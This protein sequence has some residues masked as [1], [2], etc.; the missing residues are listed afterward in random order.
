M[1][2]Y[3]D[4]DVLLDTIFESRIKTEVASAIVCDLSEGDLFEAFVSPIIIAN[5]YYNIISDAKAKGKKDNLSLVELASKIEQAKISAK[6]SVKE[7][8]EYLKIAKVDE[9]VLKNAFD[10][11]SINDKEDAIQYYAAVTSKCHY[12]V[13]R[14]ISHFPKS[15]QIKIMTPKEFLKISKIKIAVKNRCQ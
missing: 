4:S 15:D 14:N 12:L 9:S 11:D 2:V 13:T 6:T 8:L 7:F 10:D 5:I 3:L 1:R